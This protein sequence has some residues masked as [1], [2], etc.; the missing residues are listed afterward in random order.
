MNEN[1]PIVEFVDEPQEAQT[2]GALLGSSVMVGMW[3]WLIWGQPWL[4][5]AV[6]KLLN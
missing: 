5:D 1:T 4:N 6:D 3:A 2:T